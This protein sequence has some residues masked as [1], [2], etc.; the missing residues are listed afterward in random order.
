MKPEVADFLKTFDALAPGEWFTLTTE[1]PA[2][3]FV[4]AL[5]DERRGLFHWDVIES[6]PGRYRVEIA[7]RRRKGPEGLSDFL[8]HEHDLIEDLLDR[9]KFFEYLDKPAEVA[10]CLT[11]LRCVLGRHMDMEESV[12]MPAIERKGADVP[13]RLHVILAE[14]AQIKRLLKDA[15]LQR[16]DGN[17]S[18]LRKLLRKL[19]A[20][21]EEHD[22]HE[23]ELVAELRGRQEE[24]L[25]DRLQRH[26]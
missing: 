2:T 23:E 17:W 12:L 21:F 3:D 4:Q 26:V 24:T 22:E 9:V 8:M 16:A 1:K 25:V 5:Q 20:A 18:G 19:G 14:H 13:A 7:R 15:E 11:E 10:R 6:A